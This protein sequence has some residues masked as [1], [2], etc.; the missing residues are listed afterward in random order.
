[1]SAQYMFILHVSKYIWN[2]IYGSKSIPVFTPATTP[3]FVFSPVK[4]KEIVRGWDMRRLQPFSASF[5]MLLWAEVAGPVSPLCEGHCSVHT[6]SNKVKNIGVP[7]SHFMQHS[8]IGT[9]TVDKM[10]AVTL[11]KPNS[12][13]GNR[14]LSPHLSSL[15][16]PAHSSGRRSLF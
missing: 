7:G 10:T 4:K 1:M 6:H 13:H 12:L 8:T 11:H 15:S 16:L 3:C 9:L 5:W 14:F 2:S